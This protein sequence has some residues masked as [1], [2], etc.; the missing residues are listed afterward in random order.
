MGVIVAMLTLIIINFSRPVQATSP[1]TITVSVD[2]VTDTDGSVSVNVRFEVT[3]DNDTEAQLE[4]QTWYWATLIEDDD[5]DSNNV[6]DE[7]IFA[8]DSGHKVSNEDTHIDDNGRFDM[9]NFTVAGED[10]DVEP[11][12]KRYICAKLADSDGLEGFGMSAPINFDDP[13]TSNT[14]GS[15]ATTTDPT[16][17]VGKPDTA[18]DLGIEDEIWSTVLLSAGVLASVVLPIVLYNIYRK[19]DHLQ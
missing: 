9:R 1:P 4:E 10:D 13:S 14:T 16:T 7:T 5:D 3:D 11:T 12:G 18:P 19:G 17:E 6:C 15:G 2:M 8:T